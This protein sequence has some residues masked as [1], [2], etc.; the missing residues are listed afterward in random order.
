MKKN[1]YD[2]LV[3]NVAG[4]S[5]MAMIAM[6]IFL[7]SFMIIVGGYAIIG[8]IIHNGEPFTFYGAYKFVLLPLCF[9]VTA[10]IMTFICYSMK[11][12]EYFERS[13]VEYRTRDIWMGFSTKVVLKLDIDWGEADAWLEEN[14][15]HIYMYL[16]HD[17]CRNCFFSS[18]ADAMAFKIVWAEHV[19]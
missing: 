12:K 1:E 9:I 18:K 4:F 15:N 5:F 14:A 2:T 8:V 7:I 13:N 10:M 3:D 16:L 11:A 19:I 6:F 17:G